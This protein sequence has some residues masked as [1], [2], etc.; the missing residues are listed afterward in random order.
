M[1]FGDLAAAGYECRRML[2]KDLTCGSAGFVP[3]DD[4]AAPVVRP[5]AIFVPCELADDDHDVLQYLKSP[6]AWLV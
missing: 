4:P 1:T 3:A 6:C 5:L 2:Q